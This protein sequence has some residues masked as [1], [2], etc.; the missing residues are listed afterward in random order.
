MG[1][2]Y[3]MSLKR[4]WHNSTVQHTHSTHGVHKIEADNI[5]SQYNSLNQY[6][7][8]D[9]TEVHAKISIYNI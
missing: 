5:Q 7:V 9:Y 6:T 4:H 3:V 8:A 2:E 1:A